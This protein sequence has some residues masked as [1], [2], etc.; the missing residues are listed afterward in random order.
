MLIDLDGPVCALAV[1]YVADNATCLFR[2]CGLQEHQVEQRFHG[3]Y[4]SKAFLNWTRS[5]VL[6]FIFWRRVRERM[7]K[8]RCKYA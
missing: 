3:V 7:T 5:A 1:G 8:T 2:S 4:F 6:M